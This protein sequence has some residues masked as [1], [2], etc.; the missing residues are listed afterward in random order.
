VLSGEI[1]PW[2]YWSL[3]PSNPKSISSG[4]TISLSDRTAADPDGG[5]RFGI[6]G[7]IV[8]FTS[9]TF[10]VY[11]AIGLPLAILPAYVHLR[12]GFSAALAGLVISV[13]YIATFLSRPWAGHIS[14]HSGAKRAVIWGMAMCTGSGALLLAAALFHGTPWLSIVCL[15]ASRLAL[16]VGESLGSTGATLWGITSVGQEHTAKVISFNGICTYGAMAFGAPLGVVLETHFGLLSLGLLTMVVCGASVAFAMGKDA[17]P[18][19]VGEHLPFQSVLGR[20][21]PHGVGL[22]LAGV[23]YSVL[24]TFVTL[25]Y[26]SRHWDG[27]AL[28]L[29]VFGVTFIV[30][31]LL[32]IRTIERFG[33]FPVA[34]VCL[35]VE[36]AGVLMLW[37]ASTPWTAF[38]AAALT[39][40]GFAL[41]F[42][43]IGVEAVRCVPERN[44]GT[45]LGVYTGFSDVSF[46][47]VGPT[48]GTVIGAFGYA[49]A[50]LFALICVVTALGIVLVLARQHE[51]ASDL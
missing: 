11:L 38:A 13:Q 35:C 51:T 12:M 3:N 9:F 6:T 16:G 8:G 4:G 41:V 10:V 28:C 26:A 45:A 34:I 17:V 1:R 27:A 20:V 5:G 31:R 21:A 42:P 39:G 36:A 50:F 23:G 2:L 7:K 47:L 40:F 48:A 33:G 43:A 49:S 14:D 46:F 18:V 30:A 29:T 44:R 22:A 24:A 25:F 37:L 32:F 19:I 15:I